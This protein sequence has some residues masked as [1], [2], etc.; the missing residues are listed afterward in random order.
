MKLF[1]P[2]FLLGGSGFFYLH[3]AGHR[4]V[5]CCNTGWE[6]CVSLPVKMQSESHSCDISESEYDNQ[7]VQCLVRGD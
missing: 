6:K 4:S 2:S 3:F 1:M 7:I 5:C